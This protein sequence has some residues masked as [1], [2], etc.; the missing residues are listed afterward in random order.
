MKYLRCWRRDKYSV[1]AIEDPVALME[2]E[3]DMKTGGPR[4]AFE[5]LPRA[6]ATPNPTRNWEYVF[7]ALLFLLTVGSCLSLGLTANVTTIPPGKSGHPVRTTGLP[8]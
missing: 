4:I 8:C 2:G 5:V 7:G 3:V 1:L 6:K